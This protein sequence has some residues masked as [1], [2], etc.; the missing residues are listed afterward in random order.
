MFARFREY[1]VWRFRDTLLNPC[2]SNKTQ[3]A[4]PSASADRYGPYFRTPK[5][6]HPASPPEKP[7]SYFNPQD[8]TYSITMREV[9]K[10]RPYQEKDEWNWSWRS[11]GRKAHEQK[12]KDNWIA[13]LLDTSQIFAYICNY[14]FLKL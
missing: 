8:S 2:Q 9:K 13:L 11:G 4:A 1:L 14:A 6:K 3:K 7:L 12:E 10:I 5:V